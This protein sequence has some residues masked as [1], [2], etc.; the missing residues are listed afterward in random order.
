MPWAYVICDLNDAEIVGAF[1]EKLLQKTNQ[2]QF[3]VEKRQ[4]NIC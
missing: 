1:Y 3:R 4:K 2:K